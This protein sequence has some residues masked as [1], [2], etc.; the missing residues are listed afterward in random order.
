MK[1][2]LHLIIYFIYQK[3]YIFHF[4]IEI[5]KLPLQKEEFHL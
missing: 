4:E 1:K 2:I 3:N 5:Q